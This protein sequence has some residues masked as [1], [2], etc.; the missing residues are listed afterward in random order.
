[1]DIKLLKK[2]DVIRVVRN[3]REY[4]VLVPPSV[5]KSRDF[6]CECKKTRKATSI[7]I[8]TKVVMVKEANNGS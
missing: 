2:G 6:L 1:M 7:D 4:R 8:R 5:A 3:S